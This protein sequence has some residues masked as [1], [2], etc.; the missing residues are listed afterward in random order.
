MLE[1]LKSSRFFDVPKDFFDEVPL[2]GAHLP[3]SNRARYPWE[4]ASPSKVQADE[5]WNLRLR[6]AKLIHRS[7]KQNCDETVTSIG[8]VP[9]CKR[10]PMS[11]LR[12]TR[13]P[14]CIRRILNSSPHPNGESMSSL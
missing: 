2:L 4:Q 5:A 13:P 14:L 11:I 8:L 7:I 12:V 3:K 6:R 1:T 10:K 9:F